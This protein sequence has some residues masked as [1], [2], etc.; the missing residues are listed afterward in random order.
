MNQK[1]RTEHNILVPLPLVY[2]MMAELDPEGLETEGRK[3]RAVLE[4]DLPFLPRLPLSR[5]LR[6]L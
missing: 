2:N 3:Q 4:G 1:P 5:F 6:P